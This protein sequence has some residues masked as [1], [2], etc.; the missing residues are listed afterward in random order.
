MKPIWFTEMGFPS[1]DACSN[2]PNVFYDPS[3]VESYFPRGSKG[4]VDFQAQRTSL[5]ATLDYLEERCRKAGNK[6]LV[7][8]RFIW[9]WDARP[10]PYWPDK[11]NIWQDGNLWKTGHWLNGKLGISTL[12]AIIAD[13][14]R[15]TGLKQNE[16]DVSQLTQDVA[17]FVVAE[18][19][20]VREV[21]EQ[22]QAAYFFDVVESR[23]MLKFIPRLP[24]INRTN[25]TTTSSKSISSI[26]HDDLVPESSDKTIEI[27]RAQELALPQKISFTYIDRMQ[28]YNYSTSI[29]AR[30]VSNSRQHVDFT[31]PI[32]MSNQLARQV[33]DITIYN[34]WLERTSYYF[35][36]PPKYMYLEPA[37]IIT[38]TVDWVNHQMRIVKI[39]LGSNYMMKISAVAFEASIYDFYCPTDYLSHQTMIDDNFGQ[40][41]NTILYVMDIVNISENIPAENEK[42]TATIN[43]AC[44]A[45]ANNWRGAIIYRSTDNG[46][47]YKQ[48]ASC[49]QR[50]TIGITLN[51]LPKAVEYLIDEK[52]EL[53]VEIFMGGKL[54]QH[55]QESLMIS[56]RLGVALIGDEIIQYENTE[57][58]EDNGNTSKYKLTTLYRGR[59]GTNAAIDQHEAGE[60]FIL[61]DSAVTTIKVP[62]NFI[63]DEITYKAV[64]IGHSLG[65]TDDSVVAKFEAVSLK[66]LA[67][68]NVKVTQDDS[69]DVII[70]WSRTDRFA[71]YIWGESPMSEAQEL[72]EI[73][74]TQDDKII[75]TL[76]TDTI[77][78][79]YS[80]TDQKTDAIKAGTE[81]N[82]TIY[83]I[84]KIVGRGYGKKVSFITS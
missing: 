44:I 59:F 16:Y 60:R 65:S 70:T 84:S 40:V 62:H 83:R 20:S 42:D 43:F 18:N 33:A 66:P 64:S 78:A 35:N 15:S 58:I 36:L 54:K 51:K 39:D 37:D 50:A 47:N 80:K 14:L 77:K 53:M 32:V 38:V 61:L 49:A 26:P 25:R 48:I 10:Y 19:C 29:A 1:V 69:N 11:L 63:G 73:D 72:Y 3:S 28:S 81:Y 23:A 55:S 31:L 56:K 9:T 13:I 41:A 12:G 57:L 2:Q 82:I 22:L 17:G 74:I 79:V 6:D 68:A 52:S 27:V 7:P 76:K 75:R 34:A 46:K 45:N 71:H 4:R 21:I 5:N 67:V 30:Q 24:E 8:R